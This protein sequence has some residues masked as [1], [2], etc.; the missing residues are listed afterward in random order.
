MPKQQP[1]DAGIKI[2]SR[3]SKKIKIFKIKKTSK[4]GILIL[5]LVILLT[6]SSL[7]FASYTSFDLP[8]VS[9][10]FQRKVDYLVAS[11]PVIPKTSKQILT[12]AFEDSRNIET[13]KETFN[14]S[15]H[16][17]QTE[18]ASMAID[19]KLDTTD[20]D[21]V[22]LEMEIAGKIAQGNQEATIDIDVIEI[23]SNL[24][25]K[26]DNIPSLPGYDFRHMSKKW[27]QIDLEKS[28]QEI[29]VQVLGDENIRGDVEEKIEEV[30]DI[31][32][33][34]SIFKKIKKLPEEKINGRTNYHLSY[35]AKGGDLVEIL[36][37]LYPKTDFSRSTIEN[38]LGETKVDLWVD[39]NTF[40]IN[41]MEIDIAVKEV[42]SGAMLQLA[43]TSQQL[44][45]R[46]SYSLSQINEPVK[47]EAPKDAQKV[48][49]F[50][51]L[52]MMI[53]PNSTNLLLQ[54]QI[55]GVSMQTS[56]FGSNVLFY[57]RLLRV[58]FLFPKT[59]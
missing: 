1:P 44:K 38:V 3:G 57:E 33:K 41:K 59:I 6:L 23:G 7:I 5:V 47:I 9:K 8:L 54:E 25:F 27:H 32:D 36:R 20:L 21:N 4:L 35:L 31:F 16:N 28:G 18:I 39:K 24:Y 2:F 37:R 10:G 53:K 45:I 56:K 48:G 55:L 52:I 49:S 34:L 11:V 43:P 40:F 58:L 15:I 30:F 22:A 51:E 13:A 17:A 29:G 19:G 42:V 12:K 50:I 46:A 26:I 14:L